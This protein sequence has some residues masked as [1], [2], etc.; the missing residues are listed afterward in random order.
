NPQRT[1]ST[2]SAL[3]IGLALV[4][5]VAVLAAGIISNFKGAVNQ[6]FIGD[7]VVTAQNNFSSLP[8]SVAE[9]V[10]H[11]PGLTA[12]ASVRGDEARIFGSNDQLN[13]V[14]PD[15]GKTVAL[16][17]KEGSQAVPSQLGDNGAFTDDSF[18]KKH[19]LHI[20]SPVS[21]ETPTGKHVD[22]VI[23][24]VFKPPP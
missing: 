15:I 17:W 22:V 19:N 21:F 6:L 12:V 13:G 16:T 18:A 2:A 3:M 10:A 20:G 11:T 14:D 9:Q 23:K 4:T 8:K 7:Y 5:L 1:A 24:G